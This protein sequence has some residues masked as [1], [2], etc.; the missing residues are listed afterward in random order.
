MT[1]TA[2]T[3][4]GTVMRDLVYYVA[5]SLD[6]YI[7]APDGNFDLERCRSFDSGVIVEEYRRSDR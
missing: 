6:G 7:A 1:D 5:V 3:L 2:Y 4:T